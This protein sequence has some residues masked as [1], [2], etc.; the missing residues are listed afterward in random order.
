MKKTLLCFLVPFIIIML[1]CACKAQSA[2]VCDDKY[3]DVYRIS[4]F[5]EDT[6]Y[7]KYM[8]GDKEL[9]A[10]LVDFQSRLSSSSDFSF[11]AFANNFIEIIEEDIPETCV[12]NHGTEYAPESHYE[13]DGELVTATEA[14]QVSENFFE[15]FPMKITDGRGFEASDFEQDNNIP[16]IL[17][18]GYRDAFQI[19]DTFEGYYVC[20]RK[21][22]TV[23]GFAD[24][25]SAFYLPA[26]NCMESYAYFIIM[27]FTTIRE[28]SYSDRAVLLQEICG[29]IVPGND[30][31]SAVNAV[32]RFLTEAGLGDLKD[33]VS[34]NEKSLA[35]LMR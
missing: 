14:I 16:V 22:F 23:I 32:K 5:L 12:V 21:I 2:P 8:N 3:A 9:F 29:Y 18:N 7:E 24:T 33:A 20:E 10:G 25:D 34:V 13:L 30:R 4:E 15:L 6:Q 11:Y 28:D 31:S 19:G 1:F 27:P 26:H 35:E 17:G